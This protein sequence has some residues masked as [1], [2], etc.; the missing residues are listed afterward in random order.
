MGIGAGEVGRAHQFGNLA[1][2]GGRQPGLDQS[3]LDKAGNRP[4]RNP[5]G[6]NH[7]V[8]TALRPLP[9][10]NVA[11][12]FRPLHS[13]MD[14]E[15]SSGQRLFGYNPALKPSPKTSEFDMDAETAVNR[16]RRG[17]P[18]EADYLVRGAA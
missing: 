13:R 2:I 12:H 3:L 4:R 11:L 15:T 16:A 10:I 7:L 6:L 9:V 8:H 18:I 14:V 1:G 17:P 5:L